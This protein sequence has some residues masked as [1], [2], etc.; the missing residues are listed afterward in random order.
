MEIRKYR[1][2][3]KL[4]QQ[5]LAD[6]IGVTRGAVARYESGVMIPKADK[7]LLLSETL[8]HDFLADI[9]KERDLKLFDKF[10]ETL[11]ER[12]EE[13]RYYIIQRL[14]DLYETGFSFGEG[15]ENVSRISFGSKQYW[16]KNSDLD[17]LLDKSFEHLKID[18]KALLDDCQEV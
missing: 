17:K 16:V 3:K 18:F 1:K 8:E 4:T 14:C 2:A 11:Q 7:L 9:V 5:E 15:A 12:E 6:A 10:Q 13:T